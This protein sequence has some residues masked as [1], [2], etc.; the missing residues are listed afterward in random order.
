MKAVCD[1]FNYYLK[2]KSGREYPNGIG[3]RKAKMR[4]HSLNLMDEEKRVL[5]RLRTHGPQPRSDLAIALQISKGAMTKLS[6]SLNSLGLV[7]EVGASETGGRG[8]PTVPLRVSPAGGYAVGV[9][10][11]AG[12]IEI[13]VVDYSGGITCQ[14]TEQVD[15][16]DPR[17]FA[18]LLDSRMHE[19][20]VRHRLLGS[21][22]LGVGLSVP[23]PALS[24]DGGRWNVVDTLPGWRNAPLKNILSETLGLPVWDRE[25]RHGGGARGI[26]SGR[27]HRALLHC[28]PAVAGAWD[29]RRGGERP[30]PP[31]W[32]IRRRWRDRDALSQWSTPSH[33][34]RP[35]R[36]A[37]GGGMSRRLP[38]PISKR[39]SSAMTPSS[40]SG[41]NGQ[42]ASWR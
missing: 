24:S 25:R 14:T 27:P 20:A 41:S 26:L 29:R 10:V 38:L 2:T 22:L 18:Q 33:D 3:V 7:E 1:S 9:T 21:R 32:R 35:H 28:G 11:H 36:D 12:I 30:Q 40:S 6:G 4:H 16:L 19:L 15:P 23:G 34:R 42:P 17:A 37:A 39:R 31:S 5:W 13:A 8:R